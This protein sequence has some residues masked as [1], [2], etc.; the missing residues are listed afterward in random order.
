[1]TATSPDVTDRIGLPNPFTDYVQFLPDEKGLP[2]RWNEQELQ[3]L[4]GTSLRNH[5][6]VKQHSLE[7]I[8][9]DLRQNTQSIP[10]CAKWWWDEKAS[11][12]TLDDF[13]GV[14]SMFRS[15]A[16]DFG[17]Q[18]QS[19]VPVM[20]MANHDH[21]DHNVALYEIDRSNGSALLML[22]DDRHVLRGYEVTINYGS[23]RSAS[24]LLHAYGF[25]EDMTHAGSMFVSFP[26][27]FPPFQTDPLAAAKFV[28]LQ[29][30]PGVKFYVSPDGRVKFHSPFVYA[31]SINEEDGLSWD[32]ARTVYGENEFQF[33]FQ[34]VA[35]DTADE[36]VGK[37][38]EHILW[39]LFQWRAH[40]YLS[41]LVDGLINE[42][43]ALEDRS[44]EEK[45]PEGITER[46]H[47]WKVAGKLRL[48]EW[49]LLQMV[50][51]DFQERVR[52]TQSQRTVT[53]S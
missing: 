28:G 41:M 31:M 29:L 27:D 15:R 26:A 51:D 5:M 45:M 48:L 4:W 12:L 6:A 17:D 53:M 10:W 47:A 49:R 25:I 40:A 9:E 33:F 43:K 39:D 21:A 30:V 18:G 19:L 36:L 32:V 11:L 46:S 44:P 3:C 16:M 1:M 2:S 42:I 14:D 37:L 35:V 8:F 13:K 34:G 22:Q 50:K 20:D 7:T 23:D 52:I 24:D 38:R